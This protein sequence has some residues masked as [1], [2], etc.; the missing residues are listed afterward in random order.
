[1]LGLAP[2]AHAHAPMLTL[3]PPYSTDK[4]TKHAFLS[5]G[6]HPALRGRV[7]LRPPPRRRDRQRKACAPSHPNPDRPRQANVDAA[8]RRDGGLG[9]Q[10]GHGQPG[11]FVEGGEEEKGAFIIDVS[12]SS[13]LPFS[14]ARAPPA[15]LESTAAAGK[16]P[17]PTFPTRRIPRRIPRLSPQSPALTHPP[18]PTPPPIQQQQDQ[19]WQQE[20]VSSPPSLP[21][22]PT[23][24]PFLKK[25]TNSCPTPPCNPNPSSSIHSQAA[26]RQR[27]A[28]QAA[29]AAAQEQQNQAW[30]QQQQQVSALSLLSVY[31]SLRGPIPPPRLNFIPSSSSSS[32]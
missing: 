2:P 6:R 10:R 12:C 3:F 11:T 31:L 20:Q 27:E 17:P 29:Q 16:P 7:G 1:M 18:C 28:E 13:L 22:P 23:N 24:T 30:Q 32:P 14:T 5:D 4:P 25:P 26:Q 8:R 19:Q 15:R 9:A 21:T